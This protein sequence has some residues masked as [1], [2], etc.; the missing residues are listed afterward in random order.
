MRQCLD[1]WR[2]L[3]RGPAVG[4]GGQPVE[5]VSDVGQDEADIRADRRD[6]IGS[7]KP[8]G[9]IGVETPGLGI[10]QVR[11]EHINFIADDER[12]Q[13]LAKPPLDIGCLTGQVTRHAIAEVKAVDAAPSGRIQE[14]LERIDGCWGDGVAEVRARLARLD[15]PFDARRLLV[16]GAL[17]PPG[18]FAGVA[19]DAQ[20]ASGR[21]VTESADQRAVTRVEEIGRF[22]LLRL[23]GQ[24]DEVAGHQR[25]LRRSI[26]R[27]RQG[28]WGFRSA[29]W[30]DQRSGRRQYSRVQKITAV[31][32]CSNL[33]SDN[34]R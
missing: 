26:E 34:C 33:L 32:H 3:D 12:D 20:N 29:R 4:E 7:G 18:K 30:D 24:A 1:P 5:L 27:E 22:K 25:P 31:Y 16:A 21:Q 14:S 9:K 13:P 28:R 6:R 2:V 23:V 15:R 10:A 17:L 11:A 8:L 19:A